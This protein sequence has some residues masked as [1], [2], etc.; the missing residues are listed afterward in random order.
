[1]VTAVAWREP[2]WPPLPTCDRQFGVFDLGRRLT[3]QLP[4]GFE[5]QEKATLPWVIRRQ[6]TTVSVQRWLARVVKDKMAIAHELSPRL[7]YRNP[8]PR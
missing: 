2:S 6:T 3:A 5:Q 4:G 8:D 7:F 1:M